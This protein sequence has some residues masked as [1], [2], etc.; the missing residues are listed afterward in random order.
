MTLIDEV[1]ASCS[2]DLNIWPQDN[3]IV[4]QLTRFSQVIGNRIDRPSTT[5]LS[6][7]TNASSSAVNGCSHPPLRHSLILVWASP[8][9]ALM[10]FSPS[11]L[12]PEQGNKS[13]QTWSTARVPRQPTS[14][15]LDFV[16]SLWPGTTGL[17]CLTSRAEKGIACEKLITKIG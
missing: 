8:A 4:T 16:R 10:V 14:I 17:I 13:F 7:L 6:R 15:G 3:T 12:H 1:F 2:L 5:T 11:K 9:K